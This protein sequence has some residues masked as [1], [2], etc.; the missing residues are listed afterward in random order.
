MV[1]IETATG[2]KPMQDIAT[3]LEARL[4]GSK[5]IEPEDDADDEVSNDEETLPE[6]DDPDS[7]D[8]EGSDE[9][10]DADEDDDEGQ[11][12]A[13]YL[14]VPEERIKHGKDGKVTLEAVIDGKKKD[15]ILKDLVSSYQL[16]GH[17]NN[18][19]IS[20][21]NERKQFSEQQKSVATELLQR[22]DKLEAMS[23]ILEK[24]LVQEYHSIDWDRLRRE[25][26][27]E[28]SAMRQEYAEQAQKIQVAQEEILAEK[29]NL[30]NESVRKQQEAMSAYAKEQM[31]KV[32]ADNPSWADESVRR[33]DLANIRSFLVDT[34]GFS[35]DDMLQ[36]TDYRLINI[37]KDAQKF[38]NGYKKVE[39]KKQKV[40]PK[41][42]KPGVT[43]ANAEQLGKAREI[44]DKRA[45]VKMSGKTADVASLIL[46]RM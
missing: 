2:E 24:Q 21:E 46:S 44:K 28:W 35:T 20:L 36:V 32:I 31:D 22:A 34:Y 5:E 15:V 6:D 39:E 25:N 42:K 41:F 16:Q 17:V 45:K 23:K 38:K 3:I 29:Q 10:V 7:E 19:S 14:G 18:K 8:D 11:T 1:D 13:A 9:L 30:S 33:G 4:F 26:P 12:L 37:I 43:K 40:V 27:S